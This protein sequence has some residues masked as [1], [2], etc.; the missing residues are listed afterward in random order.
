MVKVSL[1][2]DSG[3]IV[4]LFYG[5]KQTYSPLYKAQWCGSL[6]CLDECGLMALYFQSPMMLLPH[7][8]LTCLGWNDEG[9]RSLQSLTSLERMMQQWKRYITSNPT[10]G[11]KKSPSDAT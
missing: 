4:E 6:G 9:S 3:V 1:V 2:G 5:C 8:L 10:P 11:I 7:P